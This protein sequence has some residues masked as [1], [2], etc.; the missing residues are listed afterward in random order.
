[1]GALLVPFL[2]AWPLV[3]W[4]VVF[5]LVAPSYFGILVLV[6]V[7]PALG[8]SSF[9]GWWASPQLEGLPTRSASSLTTWLRRETRHAASEAMQISFSRAGRRRAYGIVL[10][11]RS[12]GSDSSS[13]CM[14]H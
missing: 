10:D 5:R 8:C 3:V 13:E 9:S 2:I 6:I 1:M 12:L 4:P 7:W 14:C 11:R